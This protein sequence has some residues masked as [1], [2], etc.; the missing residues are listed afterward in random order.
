MTRDAL[1]FPECFYERISKI[2]ESICHIPGLY[3]SASQEQ[4]NTGRQSIASRVSTC[5]ILC[6]PLGSNTVPRIYELRRLIHAQQSISR[7]DEY[8]TELEKLMR[9]YKII[10]KLENLLSALLHHFPGAFRQLDLINGI[11]RNVHKPL[12]RARHIPLQVQSLLDRMVGCEKSTLALEMEMEET[13]SGDNEF[14]QV[15]NLM[16]PMKSLDERI[17]ELTERIR[18]LGGDTEGIDLL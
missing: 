7:I 11:D 17:S 15:S 2:E 4:I 3:N 18:I 6:L 13:Q 10:G 5:L 9:Q 1:I 8:L 16:R 12:E 14:V